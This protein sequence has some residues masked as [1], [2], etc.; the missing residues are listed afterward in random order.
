MLPPPLSDL[1]IN[2]EHK[3]QQLKQAEAALMQTVPQVPS[4]PELAL[5]RSINP[6][7][8]DPQTINSEQI[9]PPQSHAPAWKSPISNGF[10]TESVDDIR[11]LW[12]AEKEIIEQAI[13]LCDDNI[14]KA[15]E[16]LGISPSTIYRKKQ[17]WDAMEEK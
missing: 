10:K 4:E 17:S 16:K 1:D 13:A 2:I 8:I 11:P 3:V 6:E 12:I 9:D 5:P 7:S 14:P 15:A